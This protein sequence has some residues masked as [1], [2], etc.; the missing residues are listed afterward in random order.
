MFCCYHIKRANVLFDVL[1]HLQFS[2]MHYIYGGLHVKNIWGACVVDYLHLQHFVL[3][4]ILIPP[5]ICHVGHKWVNSLPIS[6]WLYVRQCNCCQ[7][8]DLYTTSTKIFSNLIL[9]EWCEKSTNKSG[10]YW[11]LWNLYLKSGQTSMNCRGYAVTCNNTRVIC[12]FR[13]DRRVVQ[14]LSM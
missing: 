7:S 1:L 5:N 14:R 11:I 3:C 2:F 8:A 4:C 6:A 10:Y 9:Y 12:I 13:A